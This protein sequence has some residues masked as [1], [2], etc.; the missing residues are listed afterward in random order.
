MYHLRAQKWDKTVDI[1]DITDRVLNLEQIDKLTMECPDAQS[2][3]AGFIRSGRLPEGQYSDLI[4]TYD[5][6][7][8]PVSVL[9]KEIHRSRTIDVNGNPKS[10]YAQIKEFAEGLF[11]IYTKGVPKGKSCNP[12]Y[13]YIKTCMEELLMKVQNNKNESNFLMNKSFIEYALG[14][15]D[16]VYL[17]KEMFVNQKIALIK[18]KNKAIGKEDIEINPDDIKLSSRQQERVKTDEGLKTAI[19][20]FRNECLDDKGKLLEYA[21]KELITNF[22]YGMLGSFYKLFYPG[23][24]FNYRKFRDFYYNYYEKNIREKVLAAIEEARRNNQLMPQPVQPVSIVVP[25]VKVEKVKK[26][27]K[28]RIDK[29]AVPEGQLNFKQVFGDTI[30]PE[31]VSRNLK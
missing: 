11:N 27:K 31:G 30:I 19:T 1:N 18:K 25:I 5:G 2:L 12:R 4:I 3:I 22:Y 16:K 23:D 7:S 28:K 14:V 15:F 29:N 6:S 13:E 8:R 10:V 9:Y 20:V 17:T 21:D 26:E 24:K